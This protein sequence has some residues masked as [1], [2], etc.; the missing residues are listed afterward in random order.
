MKTLVRKDLLKAL[1]KKELLEKF[2][3]YFDLS[4]KENSPLFY[5]ISRIYLREWN[6]RNS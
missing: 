4:W 5:R 3:Q 1:T 6:K 2:D